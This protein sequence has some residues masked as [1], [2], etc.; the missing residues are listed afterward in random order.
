[1]LRHGRRAFAKDRRGV[2]KLRLIEA[3]RRSPTSCAL[4]TH[5]REPSSQHPREAGSA[6]NSR[7]S[8]VC[9]PTQIPKFLIRIGTTTQKI[10]HSYSNRLRRCRYSLLPLHSPQWPALKGTFESSSDKAADSGGQPNAAL[11]QEHRWRR[12]RRDF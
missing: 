5:D 4:G 10:E 1:M 6:R 3:T 8:Q 12:G 11:D 2:N 9:H 7:P